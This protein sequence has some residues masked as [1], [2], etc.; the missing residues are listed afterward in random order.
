MTQQGALPAAA[1]DETAPRSPLG[2]ETRSASPGAT[3]RRQAALW[4]AGVV[5]LALIAGW[6]AAGRS[7]DLSPSGVTYVDPA[8]VQYQDASPTR[9]A[10]WVVWDE[11]R[12]A[13]VAMVLRN[14]RPW[15]VTVAAMDPTS[16]TTTR[17]APVASDDYGMRSLSDYSFS[18]RITVP[19]NGQL[20]LAVR[21]SAGCVAMSAGAAAGTSSV[22]VGATSLGVT[23]A[24]TIELATAF[25]AGFTADHEPGSDCAR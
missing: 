1:G 21:I 7:T 24:E 22:T 9:D 19:A 4:T 25:T 6:Q 11:S 20:L 5:A 14:P 8:F 10:T 16:V 2:A 3:R 17:F 12:G 18:D 15:P 23:S 13:E